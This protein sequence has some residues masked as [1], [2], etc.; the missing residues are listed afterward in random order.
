MPIHQLTHEARLVQPEHVA[1]QTEYQDVAGVGIDLSSRQH[2]KLVLAGEGAGFIQ[3][4][5]AV[6]V[7]KTDA[8]QPEG[9]RLVYQFVYAHEAIIGFGVAVGMQVYQQ[10]TNFLRRV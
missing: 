1:V 5:E 3:G 6:V 8:I 4:P 9:F 10:R 2:Q 7:G